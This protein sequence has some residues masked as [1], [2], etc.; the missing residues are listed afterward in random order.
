M[1]E[2]EA[3]RKLLAL[4]AA[5]ALEVGELRRVEEHLRECSSCAAEWEAWRALARGMRGLPTPQ[6]P[7]LLVE[8]TRVQMYARLAAGRD[9]RLNA[10]LMGFLV[11]FSWTLVLGTWPVVRMVTTG[12]LSWLD[13]NFQ[14]TWTGLAGYTLMGWVVGGIAALIIGLRHAT[15][16]R[17]A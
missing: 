8:R 13:L 4:A 17:A 3:I 1:S 11:L 2:H 7:A 6:A 14:R 12:A 5:E 10:W 16:R 15:A 9:R